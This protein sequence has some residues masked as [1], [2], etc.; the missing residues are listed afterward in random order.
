M[1]GSGTLQ[2]KV[3][4]P[5]V[6]VLLNDPAISFSMPVRAMVLASAMGHTNKKAISSLLK[7]FG[8][9][10]MCDQWCHVGRANNK[11]FFF[12]RGALP[13]VPIV[14]STYPS[15]S[16]SFLLSYL[17]F[18]N[19]T[20]G[21]LLGTESDSNGRLECARSHWEFYRFVCV[22]C[23]VMSRSFYPPNAH[24]PLPLFSHF[25]A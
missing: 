7:K 23:C 11:Y 6:V 8:D 18:V 9:P 16:P 5:S 17:S 22:C 21:R 13:H 15:S 25:P 19:L 10:P 20:G 12:T 1:F 14:S 3:L 4:P 24:R 2:T